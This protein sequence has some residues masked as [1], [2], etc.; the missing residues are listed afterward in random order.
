MGWGRYFL[1]GDIGQQL[2][3]QDR[4]REMDDIRQ[5]LHSQ[6]DTDRAQDQQIETLRRENEEL[7]LYVTALV[8]LLTRKGAITDAEVRAMVEGVEST[9]P[10]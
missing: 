8:R 7:Q 2:D 1:L 3:L 4:Q 5:Y 10:K 6:H 9:G